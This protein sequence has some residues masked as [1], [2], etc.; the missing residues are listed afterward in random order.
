RLHRQG[1]VVEMP[2]RVMRIHELELVSYEAGIAR[3]DLLVGSGTSL[4]LIPDALGGHCA[5][6]RRTGIGPFRV[7]EA[8]EERVVPLEEALPRLAGTAGESRPPRPSSRA[9]R[10]RARTAPSTASP[11][12]TTRCSGRRST[13][14][15]SRR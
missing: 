11:A 8:D 10:A 7:E 12:D 3:L 4:P 2:T 6:L 1:V 9:G 15:S 14:A 13:P 5:A